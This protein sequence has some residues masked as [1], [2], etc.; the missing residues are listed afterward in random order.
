MNSKDFQLTFLTIRYLTLIG[1]TLAKD[2]KDVIYKEGVDPKKII[3]VLEAC[4]DRVEHIAQYA[5]EENSWAHKN[6]KTENLIKDVEWLL[7]VM[8]D[9]QAFF[10][11]GLSRGKTR[12]SRE[13]V[14]NLLIDLK[15]SLSSEETSSKNYIEATTSKMIFSLPITADEAQVFKDLAPLASAARSKGFRVAIADLEPQVKP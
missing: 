2:L 1:E 7:F 10:E 13:S 9:N 3:D 11:K 14:E 4:F 12:P 6:W 15:A 5:V 8:Q